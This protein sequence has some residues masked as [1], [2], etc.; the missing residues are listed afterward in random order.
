MTLMVYICI[1]TSK[2]QHVYINTVMKYQLHQATRFGSKTAIIRPMQP[3][4]VVLM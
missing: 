3:K 4:Y 2:T 1:S